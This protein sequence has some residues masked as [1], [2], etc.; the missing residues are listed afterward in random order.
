MANQD[1][2]DYLDSAVESAILGLTDAPAIDPMGLVNINRGFGK[3]YVQSNVNMYGNTLPDYLRQ[4]APMR[5]PEAYA[6]KFEDATRKAL[7]YIPYA[8]LP[9]EWE[10]FFGPLQ[11]QREL[12]DKLFAS[13][14]MADPP[15]RS[16][17]NVPSSDVLDAAMGQGEGMLSIYDSSQPESRFSTDVHSEDRIPGHRMS[18]DTYNTQ[19]A[20]KALL[21]SGPLEKAAYEYKQLTTEKPENITD[22]QWA[23]M[24]E[25]KEKAPFE[26]LQATPLSEAGGAYYF[27]L[28]PA[29]EG[30]IYDQSPDR[31]PKSLNLPI[32]TKEIIGSP[33]AKTPEQSWKDRGQSWTDRRNELYSTTTEEDAIARAL[34]DINPN[35]YGFVQKQADI[36]GA[37]DYLNQLDR[38]ELI[39][40]VSPIAQKYA[41]SNPYLN[42]GTDSGMGGMD[43]GNKIVTYEGRDVMPYGVGEQ[44]MEAR[45]LKSNMPY[46]EVGD[47]FQ[48]Q[49][50]P[51]Y[52]NIGGPEL[53]QQQI[54]E[55]VQNTI[56]I[57]DKS[58]KKQKESKSKLALV[59][60]Q[61]RIKSEEAQVR[62]DNERRAK[63]AK[64]AQDRAIQDRKEQ[65]RQA[66]D[67]RQEAQ[68]RE[69]RIREES[70]KAGEAQLEADDKK[71]IARAK[72]DAERAEREAE[73]AREKER[74]AAIQRKEDEKRKKAT[75]ALLAKQMADM[76]KAMEESR[77][78]ALMNRLNRG[79]APG[80]YLYDI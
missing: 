5:G 44:L 33:V 57:I 53:N 28:P 45:G 16:I 65:E 78:K 15:E 4:Q 77:S 7:S 35:A 40:Y 9:E 63:D 42:I 62:L 68:D 34:E 41:R 76:F 11:A 22:A 27:G 2:V 73:K 56:D 79:A 37:V 71:A 8:D 55:Q 20:L 23:L 49:D 30:N 39:D 13:G 29:P 1:V 32:P 31:L 46:V 43:D 25:A 18:S 48:A 80:Q 67:R 24:K 64:A 58:Q 14:V 72:A 52:Y 66:R 74:Q 17:V 3:D 6:P 54:E 50:K 10:G 61:D 26:I 69:N 38:K 47:D 21:A 59:K 60:E 12:L 70:R 36:R 75:D 19:A 51:I